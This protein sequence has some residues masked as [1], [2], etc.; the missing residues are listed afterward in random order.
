MRF[1]LTKRRGGENS[2]LRK[3]P[4]VSAIFSTR[5]G[6]FLI[7]EFFHKLFS[8]TNAAQRRKFSDNVLE[9]AFKTSI[10]YRKML[11]KRVKTLKF[12]TCGAFLLEAAAASRRYRENL[13]K[14]YEISLPI[15]KPPPLL[16]IWR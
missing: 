6:G 13:K 15:R 10:S 16:K 8:S 14:A 3:P 4:L 11:R 1:S 9:F 7:G 2:P 12:F 5:G